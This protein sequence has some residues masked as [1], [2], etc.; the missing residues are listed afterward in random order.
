MRV[1]N[2]KKFITKQSKAADISSAQ[3]RDQIIA[4]RPTSV[5][6]F[7]TGVAPEG[8]GVV[9]SSLFTVGPLSPSGM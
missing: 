6:V 7:V 9:L 4:S 5:A 3:S 1:S 8:I 2:E